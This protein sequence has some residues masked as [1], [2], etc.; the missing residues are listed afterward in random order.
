M[1]DDDCFQHFIREFNG[2]LNDERDDL[3]QKAHARQTFRCRFLGIETEVPFWE[4]LWSPSFDVYVR[5]ARAEKD[6]RKGKG[7]RR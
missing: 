3:V 5:T 2:T 6:A 1:T 4:E 7:N